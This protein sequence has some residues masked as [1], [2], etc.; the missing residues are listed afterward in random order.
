MKTGARPSVAIGGGST[1][2][3]LDRPGS[4]SDIAL[5]TAANDPRPSASFSA[6][7][8]PQR[9]PANTPPVFPGLPACA[10]HADR[11][12]RIWPHLLRLVTNGNVGQAPN[13]NPVVRS[14]DIGVVR[15]C[16]RLLHHDP[17]TDEEIRQAREWIARETKAAIA[18]MGDYRVATF[19]GTVGAITS[20]A[21]MAQQLPAYEPARIHNY[22]LKLDTIRELEQTLLS[23]KK[24]DRVGL[25]GLKK[26]REEVIAAGAIIIRMIME[27]L[28][29]SECLV[30]DLGLRE[31]VLID[32][33]MRI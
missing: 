21:A 16:E 10:G 3:I 1:E 20:L 23:R 27:T 12:P 15:L 28:S 25:P 4:L 13:Q 24:A 14:I 22:T 7:K 18:D 5:S 8:N 29:V 2:F 30:S 19:V 33:A 6:R 31:G 11:R 32:L 9:I 17:P 26:G